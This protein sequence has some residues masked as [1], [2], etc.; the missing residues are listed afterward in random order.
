MKRDIY[1]QVEQNINRLAE[2]NVW[3]SVPVTHDEIDAF[4]ASKKIAPER[5]FMPPPAW[6]PDGIAGMKVLLLAGAGGQQAP[7]FA[8]LGA[9]VTVIDL[10]ENMLKQDRIVAKR[11]NLPIKIIKGN[12]CD[13]SGFQDSSFDL[14]VNPPSLF[15]V[16][17]VMPVFR[18]CYRVLKNGGQLMICAPNPINYICDYDSERDIYIARNRLPYIS[19]EHD[20]QGD[21]VE[22]GHSLESYIGGQIRCGFSIVGFYEGQNEPICDACF[23]TRAKK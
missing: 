13:L 2:Q 5:M 6:I 22:F 16:P 7:L 21:W 15:Y 17:E 9:D 12:I 11:E 8:A 18:E 20:D 14:I 23:V 10:S 3:F 1:R 4:K 19:Y